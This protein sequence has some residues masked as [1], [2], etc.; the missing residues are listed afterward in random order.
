[1][2]KLTT[3]GSWGLNA[4]RS[5]NLAL[6]A[7]PS[8]SLAL[9]VYLACSPG[10]SARRERLVDLLWADREPDA[11]DH[12]LRQQIWHLRK[13][14]GDECLTSSAGSLVLSTDVTCD[15]NLF[16]RA[17]EAQDYGG[18][19]ALYT[20]EFLP[21][22]AAPGG[23]DFE[24]W[25]DLERRRLRN[26]FL[27]AC[28]ELAR[29]QLALGRAIEATATARQARNEAP[30]NE[31]SWRLLLECLLAS[32]D[33][34]SA[35][36]EA[37][38][39][40]RMLDAD[41]RTPEKATVAMIRRALDKDTSKAPATASPFV[42]ELVGR[43]VPFSVIAAGW[44][45]VRAGRGRHVHVTGAAGFGKTRLLHEMAARIGS[46]GAPPVVVRANPGERHVRFAFAAEI[47]ASLAAL[48][49]ASAVSP[50]AAS[51][52]IAL[53]PRVSSHFSGATAS[54]PPREDVT[55][56]FTIAVAELVESIAAEGPLA[57]FVDDIHWADAES[58]H[59]VGALVQ[60]AA[61][62][63]V[64]IVSTARPGA[65]GQLS[66][67]DTERIELRAF[68]ASDIALLLTSLGT[69]PDAGWTA[70]LAS[71]LHRFAQGSPLL[72]IEALRLALGRD[73]LSLTDGKWDSGDPVRLFE[74]LTA[75]GALRHRITDLDRGKAWLLC[76]LAVAGLPLTP[77]LVAAVAAR[78]LSDVVNDLDELDRLGL[79][80][81]N[82][83]AWSPAHDE[84]ADRALELATAEQ[85][86]AAH[87]ALG[88]AMAHLDDA[89][90][91]LQAARHLVDASHHHEVAVVGSR[92][93]NLTREAGDPRPSVD[94]IEELLGKSRTSTEVARVLSGLPWR[95][96][97]RSLWRRVAAASAVA[98][99][100][101]LALVTWAAVG[102]SRLDVSVGEWVPEAGGQS[103]L[104]ARRLKGGD[105][106]AGTLARESLR[107]SGILSWGWNDGV[108]RPGSPTSWAATRAYADSGGVDVTLGDENTGS[109]RRLTRSRG[110]DW[111][112][113]WSP[114][115]KFLAI[116]TDR[117]SNRSYSSIAILDPE[118]PDSVV[119]LSRS[120]D[121]RDANP[122]WSPDGSRIAFLRSFIGDQ[123]GGS[124]LCV[125]TVDGAEERCLR[126]AGLN[127]SDVVGWGAAHEVMSVFTNTVGV[128]RILAV[129]TE[130]HAFRELA[131]GLALKRSRA[132]GWIACVC[133]R[134]QSEPF[135][136][137][138][139]SAS[140]VKTAIRILPA[141]PPPALEL[142]STNSIDE[143]L[144]R[145]EIQPVDSAIP[146]DNAFRL[147]VRG[148]DRHRRPV[149][150]F[151][152]RWSSADTTVADVTSDGLLRP[153]RQGQT[154]IR[155]TAGGWRSDSV[156]LAIGPPRHQL[157]VDEDW[158]SGISDVWKAFGIPQPYVS[159]LGRGSALVPNGDSTHWS[160]VLSTAVLPTRAGLGAEFTM[161]APITKEQWQYLFFRFVAAD[162][163]DERGWD[164]ALG[165]LPV[166]MEGWRSCGVDYPSGPYLQDSPNFG[167]SLS[168]G[169]NRTI[170][171][172][173]RDTTGTWVKIRIQYFPDGRCGLAVNGRA[174]AIIERPVAI[175]DSAKLHIRSFS[176]RARILVGPVTIWTGV[177]GGVDWSALDGLPA[178][179]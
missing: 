16:L 82:G 133:R 80:A 120:P 23:T 176:H 118:R 53:N 7:G 8:K 131:E 147:R 50:A 150:P 60:R 27:L 154:S 3:L 28:E 20:G 58:R 12:A 134:G 113:S 48:P 54:Q 167:F 169:L 45:D 155:V 85:V 141:D 26:H 13:R 78:P 70:D 40:R 122:A 123:A 38:E 59:L 153:K 72:T 22:F 159:R 137:L 2:L 148:F 37:G 162:A 43:E 107:P 88:R 62:N 129:N 63:R 168:S 83:M 108:V 172:P 127:L 136:S 99:V 170:R 41:G 90:G 14:L 17:I 64:F 143:H 9:L 149:E 126:L 160:G 114:D 81:R 15:R 1:M 102:D 44:K 140:D 144:E 146:A 174:A 116:A 111:T 18:A 179:P 49:G 124:Q 11:A 158:R 128:S 142:T 104:N 69:L 32:G 177:R 55:R 109:V 93:L 21:G 76:V 157:I 47:A 31:A 34:V 46:V 166:T 65:E 115:G 66:R 77:T 156:R 91:L 173:L 119:R 103:R 6:D 5:A 121:A 4:D 161:S 29:E 51:A 175:G 73:L 165:T 56:V 19:V 97:F 35:Q 92:W 89:A 79:A 57:L 98:L 110:D 178:R 138:L 163:G 24:L 25:A 145:L 112:G 135:Q 30:G 130:S 164:L 101:T 52:L 94:L 61:A 10:A 152:V 139:I 36:V 100:T 95:L 96:R 74:L 84:I 117:W 87:A 125:V 42:T 39:L 33:S 105:L 106:S 132:A 75:G 71:V 86:T 171:G 67:D 68:D 151:A